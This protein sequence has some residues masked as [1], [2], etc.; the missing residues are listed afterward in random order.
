MFLGFLNSLKFFLVLFEDL[1]WSFAVSLSLYLQSYSYKIQFF[2]FYTQT[3]HIERITHQA[4]LLPF[5]LVNIKNNH[6]LVINCWHKIMYRQWCISY[7]R[8]NLI[9]Y[10][11]AFFT[12]K[13]S[14]LFTKSYLCQRLTNSY[15]RFLLF[16]QKWKYYLHRFVQFHKL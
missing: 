1:R 8:W 14:Q 15:D 12:F 13:S 10:I 3:F 16:L 11:L 4:R 7:F 5:R 2:I 6:F 9:P